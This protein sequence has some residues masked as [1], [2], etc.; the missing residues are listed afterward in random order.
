[1]I[2]VKLGGSLFDTPELIAWMQSLAVYSKQIPIVIV[3]GGGPFADQVRTADIYYNLKDKTAHQMALL[4]MKQFGLLLA[5]IEPTAK[6]INQNEKVTSALSIWLPDDSLL[7]ESK[8]PHSW[9]IS[10]DSI[11]LW[12]ASKLAAQQLLLVKRSQTATSSITQ[13]TSN[14]IIDAGFSKLFASNKIDTKI[15]HYANFDDFD[16]ISKQP[17]LYLP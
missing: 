6:L 8:L 7:A 9:D 17:S 4:A 12:L 2:V 15:L 5:D 16:S 14:S 11:A 3:P 1:M 13:L 10:S